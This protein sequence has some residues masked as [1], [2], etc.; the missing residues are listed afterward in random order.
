MSFELEVKSH[1]RIDTAMLNIVAHELAVLGVPVCAFLALN[2]VHAYGVILKWPPL[3]ILAAYDECPAALVVED[4]WFARQI[5][6]RIAVQTVIDQKH[7]VQ[8][9]PD[10]ALAVKF[11]DDMNIANKGIVLTVDRILQLECNTQIFI[12]R[13]SQP[14]K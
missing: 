9:Q 11:V 3:H 8:V 2:A 14:D 12:G 6:H 13:T 7:L 1:D 10:L 5:L 4:C